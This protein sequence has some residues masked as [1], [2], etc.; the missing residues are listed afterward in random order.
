MNGTY[1]SNSICSGRADSIRIHLFCN[2]NAGHIDSNNIRING[3]LINR[4]L[5]IHTYLSS[6]YT[7]NDIDLTHYPANPITGL[8]FGNNTI[9]DLDGNGYADAIAEGNT[10]YVT[11]TF[12]YDTVSC[13]PFTSCSNQTMYIPAIG[14]KY[15]NECYTL[16]NEL[17]PNDDVRINKSLNGDA[18]YLYQTQAGT[19][20][21]TAPNDVLNQSEF[22][23]T[24]CANDY[25]QSWTPHGFNFDCPNAD[26]TMNVKLPSGYSIDTLIGNGYL[27][28]SIVGANSLHSS[29]FEYFPIYTD[30]TGC[31][32]SKVD[33]LLPRPSFQEFYNHGDTTLVIDFG[34]IDTANCRDDQIFTLACMNIPL[35]LACDTSKHVGYTDSV[36]FTLQY[37][38]DPSCVECAD[39]LACGSTTLYNHPCGSCNAVPN[40][41]NTLLNIF[42]TN[43]GY[44]NQNLPT[45]YTT[46]CTTSPEL[47]L[48]Q[49]DTVQNKS[50]INLN[51]AYQGD[52]VESIVVGS[53][54]GN[55]SI[56]SESIFSISDGLNSLINFS[57][58]RSQNS[59][60]Y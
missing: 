41:T 6:S 57:R 11:A 37:T 46:S 33:T 50:G 19:S 23:V 4:A 25:L 12:I 9:E 47:M 53:Y 28:D 60:P 8:A 59:S 10:F 22:I 39:E 21:V 54:S 31:P 52:Q 45:Y 24:I 56:K 1:S 13:F 15:N 30:S 43:V 27:I 18:W 20:I 34:K 38:C 26:Y 5:Y 44:M 58:I 55:E 40:T 17:H 42:R 36:S 14:A 32:H 48:S 16:E 51:E 29:L 49:T 7:V 2:T 35:I 3:V